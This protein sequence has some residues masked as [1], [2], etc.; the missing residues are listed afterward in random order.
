[1]L[2]HQKRHD[3]ALSHVEEALRLNPELAA[4]HFLKGRV[5]SE[6]RQWTEAAAYVALI[7]FF[8]SKVFE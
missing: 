4:A 8:F 6:K 7:V 1:V 2:E 5:H 3:D